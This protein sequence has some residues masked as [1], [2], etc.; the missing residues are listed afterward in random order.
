MVL[1]GMPAPLFAPETLDSTAHI[2][3]VAL[4]PVFLLSGIG[5]L[6]NV[7]CTRLGRVADKIQHVSDAIDD[8]DARRLGRL[9]AQLSFLRR[10][11]YLLDTAVVLAALGGGATCGATMTLFVGALRDK[12]VASALYVMFGLAV[13]CT[14]GALVAFMS[15][16]LLASRGLRQRMT[17][18]PAEAAQV[19]ATAARDSRSVAP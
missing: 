12:G 2:I 14:L 6:M 9:Q 17:E 10:R 7:F 3:Q 11:S 16:M 8:A 1:I 15:E 4:T 19:A 18:L 13:F 5:T